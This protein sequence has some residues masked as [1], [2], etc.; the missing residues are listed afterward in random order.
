MPDDT[1]LYEV[2]NKPD[3]DKST[4]CSECSEV[5]KKFQKDY[6]HH[7]GNKIQFNITDDMTQ[8]KL[9]MGRYAHLRWKGHKQILEEKK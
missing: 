6:P 9:L 5:M 1:E 4:L 8:K 3:I 2:L 7:K